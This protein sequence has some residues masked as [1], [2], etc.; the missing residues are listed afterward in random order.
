VTLLDGFLV[1]SDIPLAKAESPMSRCELGVILRVA[2]F[3]DEVE[4]FSLGGYS[5]VDTHY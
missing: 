2:N 5:A 1:T 4:R 3:R